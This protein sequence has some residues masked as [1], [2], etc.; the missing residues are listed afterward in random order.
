[1]INVDKL[2]T[3]LYCSNIEFKRLEEYI[4]YEQPSKYIVKS[5]QYNDEYDIP[6]LTAGQ[7]FVLGYTNEK[8]GIFKATK[9]NPVIIFDDFTT[10]FHWVDFDFKVKSSALKILKPKNSDINFRYIYYAMSF[11]KYTPKNH[12]RHWISVYSKF[13]IPMPTSEAQEI[14]VDILDKFEK[15]IE[16]S[17]K[18]LEIRRQQ[19]EWLKFNYFNNKNNTIKTNLYE[20]C[21]LKKGKT[22]IQKATPGEY[23]LVVTT[24]E[25]KS[26]NSFDF[27]GPAVCVPLVSSRG[28]GIASLNQVFYQDGKYAVGNIL[29]VVKPKNYDILDA[30]YLYYYLNFFKD[31]KIVSLMKGGANVSLTVDALKNVSI[32]IPSIDSQIKIIEKFRICDIVI[33][34]LSS[35]IDLLKKQYEYYRDKLLSF[36]GAEENV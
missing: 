26:C 24:K 21:E 23:P 25:R 2:L 29:C 15:Q 30:R 35:K 11:I 31:T 18:K 1:M 4:D 7:T 34:Q 6:V 28:H 10:S 14:I 20:C 19:I 16:L 17:E 8:E 9:E 27:E 36:K 12:S 13:C 33:E 5:T 3:Q 22:P 32:E